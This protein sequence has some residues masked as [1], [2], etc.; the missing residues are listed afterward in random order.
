MLNDPPAPLTATPGIETADAPTLQL[1][2]LMER[3][4][5]SGTW[6][7]ALPALQPQ[8]SAQLVTLLEM[9]PESATRLQRLS[10]FFAPESRPMMQAALDA[11]INRG[12]PFDL[13]AQAITAGG[14]YLVVRS[15]GEP[16]RDAT[17][18][19]TQAHGVIQDITEKRRA[20]QESLSVTMRLSTTLASITEAFVTLDRQGRFTY[21]NTESEYMLRRKSVALLGKKI[22]QELG[23]SD[24]GRLRNDVEEALAKGLHLEFED[25]YPSLGKWLALRAYPF[26][27]G[28]AVY[29][30]DVTALRQSQ[31]QLLLLQ[32][33][34]SR[35]NDM[36]LITEAGSIDAPGPRIVFVN[37]AFEK[38]TGYSRDEVLGNA[39]RM[40]QGPLTQRSELDRIRAA[41]LQ[42]QPVRAELINYKKNGDLYWIELEI[43]PVDYFNRGLTHWVAVA[44]DITER[45]AAEDEIEH[46][47][48]YDTL[49]QLPNRQLLMDRLKMALA[50]DAGNHHIG[51]LMFIDLDHFKVLNDSLGHA[52]GDMLLQQVATRLASSV[53]SSDTVAR[54]G[55]DEFVVMLENLGDNPGVAT[56]TARMVGEKIRAALGAPY[57]LAD[58]D[59]HG[60]CSIGITCF[61]RQQHSIGDLLKQADL[62]MYQAK[63]A[64]RNA[65][66]F[67]DPE[68]Q[69]A[70]TASA[71]LSSQLREALHD[72]QFVLHY[73]P[74]VGVDSRMLGVEALLRWQHPVRGLVCPDEFIPQAEE[75]GLILPLGQWVLEK[76][77]A[78]LALWARNADTEKLSIAVNV[79]A[80]QFRHP[81]FVEGVLKVIRHYG[82]PAN[83]LKLEL[84]ESLLAT[85]MEVTI[86]KMGLLKEAGVTLSIDDFGMGYSA[87]SY[88]KYLPLDQLKID[89]TFVKDVLTDPNDAAIARTI[90][91]LAQSLGLGVIA[92]G[93]ETEAQRAFL[94]W[95]GCESYQGHLFCAA[96]PIDEL[97]AFMQ[98]LPG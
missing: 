77:C 64:G 17:G 62:A 5:A 7:L 39:P 79:S 86:A 1:M 55:G 63:A 88:L 67:F 78:Q 65:V 45:K 24:S 3:A 69:A 46:L 38:H 89:R 32:T 35:L 13:E 94:A 21:L 68:M 2:V 91:G 16:V 98:A 83:R 47:A 42:A 61:S 51:V 36:V 85:G 59:Y 8:L 37:D 33:S 87:L 73:Q 34:I 20:E 58:H 19:I 43:V 27:E 15:I 49:T 76:A 57:D 48:F 28:M 29:L 96:L 14:S 23:D 9:T 66:C 26:E 60:T 4:S 71:T 11:C 72:E 30:R 92:E 97:D 70:A 18:V 84:T 80:R 52:R 25:F 54:L 6:S 41:L 95:H 44:R 53:R 31:E 93:V 50:S 90:I 81:E 56:A 74:Q 10:D 82:I 12:T 22:W 75:S 40:L